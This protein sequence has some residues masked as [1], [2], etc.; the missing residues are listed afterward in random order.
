MSSDGGVSPPASDPT[1]PMSSDGAVSPDWSQISHRGRFPLGSIRPPAR[2]RSDVPGAALPTSTARSPPPSDGAFFS[3][4]HVA[5][6]KT[7][8]T[9]RP[10]LQSVGRFGKSLVAL[11]LLL[12]LG[13]RLGFV[14]WV[15]FRP[16]WE[17]IVPWVSD[18]VKNF[19]VLQVG[20]PLAPLVVHSV[21][22]MWY[23][24]TRGGLLWWG[25]GG[26][27]VLPEL[28]L[29]RTKT[30]SD[31]SPASSGQ[32]TAL[33]TMLRIQPEAAFSF[34][35]LGRAVFPTVFLHFLLTIFLTALYPFF[36]ARKALWNGFGVGGS[37]F[38]AALP[39]GGGG[40]EADFTF[41]LRRPVEKGK[42]PDDGALIRQALLF[43]V[44]EEFFFFHVGVVGG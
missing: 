16:Y 29:P 6:L 39:G 2:P 9:S 15:F 17:D 27:M 24:L 34:R 33:V 1:V 14:E 42:M 18:G 3:R 37:G 43:L 20:V 13:Y 23:H 28:L 22:M 40:R 26:L 35:K 25:L 19:A 32:L 38:V 36:A 4:H 7:V 31:G 11:F 21:A 30:K 12:R 5:W 10:F 44:G 41:S 8:L